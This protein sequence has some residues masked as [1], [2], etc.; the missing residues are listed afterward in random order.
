DESTLLTRLRKQKNVLYKSISETELV[1]SELDRHIQALERTGDIMS[2]QNS[3]DI[4]LVKTEDISVI[5]T[6]QNMSVEDFSRYYG[7]LYKRCADENIVLS[8]ECMAF[9]YDKEFDPDNSD[10]ELALGVKEEEKADKVIKGTLCASTV[11]FGAYSKLPEAYGA[12]TRWIGE[13]GYEITA[14]P[15]EIYV[16][17]H[18][19]RIPVDEWETRIF[20]PVKMK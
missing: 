16:T 5:A 8:G 11:H 20:F 13:N 1:I 9:Y 3:Y 4:N 2:Y 12:I 18:F 6:R 10:I 14:P 7:I 15:Y 19:D 17:S